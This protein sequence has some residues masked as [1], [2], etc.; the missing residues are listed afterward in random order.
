MTNK[1][2]FGVKMTDREKDL[3][4]IGKPAV[5]PACRETSYL[6]PKGVGYQPYQW[7][8]NCSLCHR[9][10][11]GLDAY[12]PQ[13]K[14]AVEALQALRERYLNGESSEAL[15]GRIEVLA[16]Q[17]DDLLSSRSCECSGSLSISAKPKCIYC[18]IEI[19]D[20]YFHVADDRP[21]GR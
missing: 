4:A 13:H 14:E 3:M 11:I 7:E 8:V 6:Y 15:A 5:C 12:I 2:P 1:N 19:V 21:D 16:E 18:D 10:A 20:S 17:Y 9:Y